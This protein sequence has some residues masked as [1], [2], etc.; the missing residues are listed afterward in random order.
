MGEGR[1]NN[2]F[3]FGHISSDPN[4]PNKKQRK[5]PTRERDKA[6]HQHIGDEIHNIC[7]KENFHWI[8]ILRYVGQILN[9]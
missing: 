8:L 1:G 2:P 3:D 4:I 5:E 7:Q 9:T 6:E